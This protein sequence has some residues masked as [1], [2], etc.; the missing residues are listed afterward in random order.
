MN[1]VIDVAETAKKDPSAFNPAKNNLV[2]G[3]NDLWKAMEPA[4]ALHDHVAKWLLE[5]EETFK[6]PYL[7]K[8][9]E[10]I[11]L[12]IDKFVYKFLALVIEPSI[13]EMRKA[14]GAGKEQVLKDDE[15]QGDD[16]Y[17]YGSHGSDPSHSII[18]KDHFSNVLNPPAGLVATVTTNWTTQQVVHC[19]DD[20][21]IDGEAIIAEILKILH[22]PAFAG[23]SSA[24]FIQNT[25]YEAVG[26]W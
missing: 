4:F 7:S 5:H 9:I 16:I 21:S 23:A 19:W 1:K 26:K 10:D 25:M 12:Y 2:D 18:A 15:E 20:S 24:S 17:K 3:P 13:E 22:C 8:A 6:I 14:V 11:G